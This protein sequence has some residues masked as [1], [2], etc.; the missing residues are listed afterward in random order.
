MLLSTF[1]GYP[2]KFSGIFIL[3]N[4]AVVKDAVLNRM[5]ELFGKYNN[6]SD[7]AG[8]DRSLHGQLSKKRYILK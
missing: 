6:L 1:F 8:I 3:N 2:G 5:S 7:R 4:T